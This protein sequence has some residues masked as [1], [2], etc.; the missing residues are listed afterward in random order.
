MSSTK[1]KLTIYVDEEVVK[2]IKILAIKSDCSLSVLTEELYKLR[3]NQEEN[4]K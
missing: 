2:A 4:E 1:K 3:L